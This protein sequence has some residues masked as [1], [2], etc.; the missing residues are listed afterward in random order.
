M[1]L[2]F[3]Q[4]MRMFLQPLLGTVLAGDIDTYGGGDV[5]IGWWKVDVNWFYDKA[6]GP[7]HVKS[8]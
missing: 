6:A 5:P 4:Q 3:P 1:Y 2:K 8:R 7:H